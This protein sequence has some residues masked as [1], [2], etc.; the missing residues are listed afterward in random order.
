MIAAQA[1][2]DTEDVL[3]SIAE[4]EAQIAAG[5]ITSV[6]FDKGP[7][8]PAATP[9]AP[10]AP[11]AAKAHDTA[12]LL[13][14]T[15]GRLVDRLEAIERDIKDQ[16]TAPEQRVV[17]NYMDGT[18]N[19]LGGQIVGM[20]RTAIEGM[21]APVVNIGGAQI[22]VEPTPV[23]LE[24]TVESPIVNVRNDV[25]VDVPETTVRV[26]IPPRRTDSTVTR[27]GA[28]EIV[29]VTQLETNA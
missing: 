5:K 21:P 22:N 27:N 23:T 3:A 14:R 13:E 16:R 9:P 19:S 15:L 11:A 8:M 10:A 29:H 17:N 7:A 28:G 18:L 26:E 20:L 6:S 2:V 12:E 24:A 1:G 4:F 25:Q